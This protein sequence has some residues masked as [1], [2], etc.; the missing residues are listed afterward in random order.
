MADNLEVLLKEAI[1]FLEKK[2]P[3]LPKVGIV[4]G[5]GFSELAKKFTIQLKLPYREIPHFPVPTVESH[6]GN[7]IFGFRNGK[8]VAVLEGRVHYYE[9]YSLN[10]VVF[11]I[12]VLRKLGV[13][14]LILTNAAGGLNPDFL[15]GEIMVIVDHINLI[16][17]NPLRGPNLEDL[18]ERFPSL[19]EPYCRK[20][21]KKVEEIAQEQKISLRK[22]VYVAVAG[23]S[24]ETAA[25]I[26]FIRMIGGDAVGM[27]TV[28][29]VIAAI[30]AGIKV[31]ALSLISNVNRP[32]ALAPAPLKEVI[33][34]VQNS[35]PILGNLI[36]GLLAR[37]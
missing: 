17:D 31:L 34:T 10:E 36:D 23:P 12:R 8:E 37:L 6:S 32:E 15:P 21:I 28:P 22:G 4:L 3:F 7:L 27:S 20:L 35:L 16:G 13:S 26:R 9:G 24:L 1:N 33:Q 30:H 14:T 29:E 25:E 18:G 19:H 5:T 2:I 11:P